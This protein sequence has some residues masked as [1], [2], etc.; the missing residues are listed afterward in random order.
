MDKADLQERVQPH[1]YA[2]IQD[3]DHPAF[4]Y[5]VRVGSSYSWERLVKR[6]EELEASKPV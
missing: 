4:Y 1:G 2:I 6:V 5:L 3:I